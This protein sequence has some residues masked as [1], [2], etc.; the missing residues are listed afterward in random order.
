MSNRYG[1]SEEP[2]EL[3]CKVQNDNN[4]YQRLNTIIRVRNWIEKTGSDELSII[5]SLDISLMSISGLLAS[6]LES[7]HAARLA[8]AELVELSLCVQDAEELIR[9]WCSSASSTVELVTASRSHNNKG[10]VKQGVAAAVTTVVLTSVVA[11]ISNFGAEIYKSLREA[12]VGDDDERVEE[13][14]RKLR[15]LEG[16]TSLTSRIPSL[17][18]MSEDEGDESIVSIE[19]VWKILFPSG[20]GKTSG[21]FLKKRRESLVESL[22]ELAVD[23]EHFKNNDEKSLLAGI[24]EQ[25]ARLLDLVSNFTVKNSN[26]VDSSNSNN[27]PSSSSSS[28]GKKA[29]RRLSGKILQKAR[30]GSKRQSGG[31][32]ENNESS[33]S[34]SR[35]SGS[36]KLSLSS[37][38]SSNRHLTPL[39]KSECEDELAELLKEYYSK[40]Q[41]LSDRLE[42]LAVSTAQYVYTAKQSRY[43]VDVTLIGSKPKTLREKAAEIQKMEPFSF[44]LRDSE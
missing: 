17:F 22:N 10:G 20:R 18:A 27:Q 44:L 7:T 38:R 25:K 34:S 1:Y 24:D 2:L 36:G 11:A 5:N 8:P 43:K 9:H 3:E 37:R 26:N 16:T 41:K 33:Q 6:H 12:F 32:Q 23:I 42:A 21:L 14:A 30:G 15:K 35:S 13:I 40:R 28:K 31:K 4:V 39:D 29:A 19:S